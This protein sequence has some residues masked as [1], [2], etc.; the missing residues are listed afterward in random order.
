VFS[1][2]TDGDDGAIAIDEA[3]TQLGVPPP[4]PPAATRLHFQSHLQLSLLPIQPLVLV[5][6][7]EYS[8]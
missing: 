2:I 1:A 6:R 7:L 3:Q 5:P 4:P 8:G